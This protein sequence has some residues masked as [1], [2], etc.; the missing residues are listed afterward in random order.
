M[1]QS[2]F[3]NGWNAERVQRLID[4]YES[5]TEDEQVADDEEATAE[6]DGQVLMTIP[7]ELVPEVRRLLARNKSA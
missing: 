4:H 5:M 6:R 2:K 3:P 1:S 7:E